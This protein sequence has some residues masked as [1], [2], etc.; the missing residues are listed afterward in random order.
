MSRDHSSDRR[1]PEE[2]RQLDCTLQH[3]RFEPRES[4]GAELMGRFRRSEQPTVQERRALWQRW[5]VPLLAG[6]AGILA[7]LFFVPEAPITVDRCCYDLDGGGLAD[8]GALVIGERDGR[9]FRLRLYEDRDG[10]SSF[11]PGDVMRYDR[12]GTVS[13]QRVRP[14]ATTI[15]HCCQDLDGGGPADD[16]IFVLATPPDRIHSAAI[17]QLR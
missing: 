4:L 8:D 7:F 1:F 11:T 13:E 3:V 2:L 14:G 10:S 6:L 15:Q 5:T 12:R 16:G 17:Y 9:V